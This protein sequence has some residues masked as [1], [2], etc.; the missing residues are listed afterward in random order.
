M[1]SR[2][3]AIGIDH[4]APEVHELSGGPPRRSSV[5]L[6]LL[7]WSRQRLFPRPAQPR[8]RLPLPRTLAPWAS[9]G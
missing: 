4:L 7:G 1:P 9:P 5:A 8:L 2:P 6:V 3:A